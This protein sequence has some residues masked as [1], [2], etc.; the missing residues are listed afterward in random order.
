M[1]T[2]HSFGMRAIRALN[3]RVR[4]NKEEK[5]RKMIADLGADRRL[6]SAITHLV[7]LGKQVGAGVLWEV[8]DETTWQGIMDRYDILLSVVQ[9]G[10]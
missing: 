5:N 3:P 6:F 9:N 7:S 2:C 1:G 10:G 8:E 4:I